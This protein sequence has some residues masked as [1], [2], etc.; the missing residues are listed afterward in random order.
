M[1]AA[2]TAGECMMRLDAA[3]VDVM[4]RKIFFA[5]LFVFAM[6]AN[7]VYAHGVVGL[8]LIHI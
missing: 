8:S 7:A 2:W 3:A 4:R 1:L 6:R 5:I